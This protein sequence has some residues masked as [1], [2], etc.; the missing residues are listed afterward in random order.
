MAFT[1]PSLPS[2]QCQRDGLRIATCSEFPVLIDGALPEW[3]EI[4][5]PPVDGAVR[6]RDGRAYTMR[7][8]VAVLDEFVRL[9]LDLPIDINHSSELAAPRGEES[10]AMGFV[11]ELVIKPGGGIWGRA[12]WTEYGRRWLAGNPYKYVSP[13]F[14]VDGKQISEKLGTLGEVI[15]LTSI[16]LTNRPNFD[17]MALNAKN[18]NSEIKS[19]DNQMDTKNFLTTLGLKENATPEQIKARIDELVEAA[20]VPVPALNSQE[21]I[22]AQIDIAVQAAVKPLQEQAQKARAIAINT[23]IDRY[24]ALGKIQPTAESKKFWA[25]SC[26]DSEDGLLRVSKHLELMPSLVST[27][28]TLPGLPPEQ[29]AGSLTDSQIKICDMLQISQDD[30]KK[31]L[32]ARQGKEGN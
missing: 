5:P 4:I 23:T 6:G 28:A 22:N 16:G 24:V 2:H 14:R 3:L 29:G 11:T 30:Y 25:D 1:C 26:G 27:N 10:P 17:L 20:T 13:A 18:D 12:E 7:D 9:G 32:A 19:E 8:P 15:A 31:T 21:A